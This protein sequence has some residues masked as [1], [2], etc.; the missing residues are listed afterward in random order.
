MSST[1]AARL[2]PP[3]LRTIRKLGLNRIPRTRRFRRAGICNKKYT[4]SKVH[5]IRG[6]NLQFCLLNAQSIRNKT[7]EMHEYIME[8]DIDILAITETWLKSGDLRKLKEATP[9]THKFKHISRQSRWAG[10]VAIVY[11]SSLN[12]DV[13]PVSYVAKSFEMMEAGVISGSTSIGLIILYRPPPSKTNGLTTSIFYQKFADYLETVTLTKAHPLL[14]GDFNFHVDV[15][16]DSKA[17]QFS[18]IVDAAGL[19]Q[20]VHEPTHRKGPHHFQVS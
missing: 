17:A 7:T 9:K 12:L 6:N 4:Y 15:T 5:K 13:K 1:L 18:A 2:P 19:V 3:V 11:K 16:S 14:V 8:K 10:G 20:H